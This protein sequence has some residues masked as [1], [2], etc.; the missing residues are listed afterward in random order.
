MKLIKFSQAISHVSWLKITDVSAIHCQALFFDIR[1]QW[2]VPE[3][4]VIFSQLTWMITRENFTNFSHHESLRSHIRLLWIS[5]RES[6]NCMASRKR[7]SVSSMCQLR[8]NERQLPDA[9]FTRKEHHG[10]ETSCEG[11]VVYLC[12]EIVPKNYI[13][14][15]N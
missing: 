14:T 4:S 3:T 15:C 1:P 10:P 6:S 12:W 11:R 5:P 2:W 13:W 8:K 7:I 9:S